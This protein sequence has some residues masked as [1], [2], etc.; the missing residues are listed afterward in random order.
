LPK[1]RYYFSHFGPYVHVERMLKKMFP[2]REPPFLFVKV[3]TSV[4]LLKAKGIVVSCCVPCNRDTLKATFSLSD[5][6]LPFYF[7]SALS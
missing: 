2:Q 7:V 3:T 5:Q 4:V 6:T 1:P